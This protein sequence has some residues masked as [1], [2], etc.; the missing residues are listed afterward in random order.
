MLVGVRALDLRTETVVELIERRLRIHV[1]HQHFQHDAERSL[2]RAVRHLCPPQGSGAPCEV[3]GSD[4]TLRRNDEAADTG[5]G[6]SGREGD[7]R[8]QG[9]ADC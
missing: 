5:R 3:S 9:H 7:S 1:P 4:S 6:P 2:H 8:E